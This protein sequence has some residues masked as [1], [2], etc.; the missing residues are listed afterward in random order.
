MHVKPPLSLTTMIG[1]IPI[2]WPGPIEIGP[3]PEAHDGPATSDS[4]EEHR[5]SV[6]FLSYF[7]SGVHGR[8]GVSTFQR[9]VC[10]CCLLSRHTWGSVTCM[11]R[12]GPLLIGME[13]LQRH[14]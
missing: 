7:L 12:P 6:P 14:Q 4:I 8:R 10:A 11:T 1:G 5:P 3:C 9:G 2:G 13:R